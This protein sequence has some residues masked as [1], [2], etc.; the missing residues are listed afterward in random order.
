MVSACAAQGIPCVNLY[1]GSGITPENAVKFKRV[2]TPDGVRDLPYPDYV[3]LPFDPAAD[4]YPSVP[5]IQEKYCPDGLHPSD[6][7]NERLAELLAKSL[8]QLL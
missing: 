6:E 8:R 1:D 4:P 3:G 2:R 7:G 5:V